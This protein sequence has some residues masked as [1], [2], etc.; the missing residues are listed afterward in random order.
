[1]EEARLTNVQETRHEKYKEFQNL[2]IDDLPA[3]FL[4]TPTYTYPINKKIKGIELQR[5]ANPFDRF[6]NIENWHTKTNKKFFK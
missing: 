5:I 1:M 6:I 2:L 3:I 4:Y